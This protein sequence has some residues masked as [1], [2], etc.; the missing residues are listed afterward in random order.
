MHSNVNKGFE[1]YAHTNILI[2]W[3]TI[4]AFKLYKGSLYEKEAFENWLWSFQIPP[5]KTN[6]ELEHNTDI[7]GSIAQFMSD[8]FIYYDL[9]IAFL[10]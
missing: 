6:Y 9:N 10:I 7:C 8:I 4:D 3:S 2:A 1:S 5:L